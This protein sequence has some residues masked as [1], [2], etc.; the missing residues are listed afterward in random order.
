MQD[1][2]DVLTEWILSIS[3]LNEDTSSSLYTSDSSQPSTRDSGELSIALSQT[4]ESP[5]NPSTFAKATRHRSSE[6]S[7]EI[8]QYNPPTSM[9]VTH[10]H[11]DQS[12]T[13][14]QLSSKQQL[15]PPSPI[16]DASYYTSSRWPAMGP[17]SD[18][19]DGILRSPDMFAPK[20]LT[21]QYT[22]RYDPYR[23]ENRPKG[24][25]NESWHS[26]TSLPT[27]NVVPFC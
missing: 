20:R 11:S 22:K 23:H 12:T 3:P 18:A 26:G 2:L 24:P 8:S 15:L 25:T 13:R 5:H 16:H 21:E 14:M 6:S 4:A 10:L 1:G 9:D 17:T 7:T 19:L 27:L